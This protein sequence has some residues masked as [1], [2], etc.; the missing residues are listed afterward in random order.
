MTLYI[1]NYNNYYNRIMKRESSIED[2][3]S[4]IIYT[5][6]SSNFNP[7]D[8]I[9]TTHVFGSNAHMYDGSGDYVLV[10][11]EY[12]QIVSRWFI[13]E[14][15]RSRQ[16]QWILDLKRDL[17]ADY[18]D[19]IIE[20]P[21]FIEKGNLLLDDPLIFNS[22]NMTVNQIK[23]EETL[24]KDET[25][26]PW[27]VGYYAKNT[28]LSG[29]VPINISDDIPHIDLDGSISQWE[30][31]P[32][33][34][35]NQAQQNFKGP[36]QTANYK[37]IITV[38]GIPSTPRLYSV[39]AFN[40]STSLVGGS[41][42]LDQIGFGQP[43]T[44]T[45]AEAFVSYG[46]NN[47]NFN[48]YTLNQLQNKFDKILSYDGKIIK[49]TTIGKYYNC[50]ITTYNT[51]TTTNISSG[52]L[53]NKLGEILSPL[54]TNYTPTTNSYT[55][56][57][58]QTEVS[59]QLE[60]LE[61]LE[62]Q[63]SITSAKLITENSPYDIFAI[64]Y[65]KITVKNTGGN[66]LVETNA[67][68][69]LTA[70][71]AIQVNTGVDIIYDIQLL[72]YCPVQELITNTGEITVTNQLQYSLIKKKDSDI[73]VGI[74]FNVSKDNFSFNI[75]NKTV[76]QG[77]SSI[78]RKINNECDKWRLASPNYSNY[79]DFSAEMNN[80][81]EFF[82]VD[83][84]YK[85]YIPYI[86]I[87]PNF[88][89]LYGSDFNDPRGLV[90]GGDFSL[91]QVNDRWQQYQINNK[92]YQNIFDRQI[93]N[94][95]F[96]NTIGLTSDI[97]SAVT[98][99]AQGAVSGGFMGN[100]MPKLG[101][102]PGAAIGAA[103]SALGGAADVVLNS[104]L[105]KEALDYTKD[106]FGFQ[107]G[108]IQALPDTISKISAFNNNNKVF[109]VLEYYT[110]KDREKLA[111]VNKVAWNG[112]TIGVIGNIKDYI[113]NTWEYNYNDDNNFVQTIKSQNYI[114]GKIIRLDTIDEDFHIVN[115]I[116]LELDKGVYIK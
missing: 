92:N 58:T 40:G 100:L 49:D 26:C 106:M 15:V 32:Y 21:C 76:E 43:T 88:D 67:Q 17:F 25:N 12:N 96:K 9:D 107:L 16:G 4:Y 74:I 23:T 10:V 115:S 83:C 14:A 13:I 79:F 54:V 34:N 62:Q 31:Y 111:F 27:L 72:P 80:G 105:R 75:T 8:G 84:N 109:P 69:G 37:F 2:Y 68:Y 77:Q 44:S 51:T 59:I 81:V 18:W 19:Q 93:Q 1:L 48:D 57:T 63:Y 33:C 50:I 55:I 78:E 36:A 94:M 103:A 3:Q 20:S 102:G 5:L 66:V 65:G 35:L 73:A 114:K 99:T 39:N 82:N 52:S 53:F 97:I 24:L 41:S 108:N 91:T 28:D 98:G 45:I 64:P 90:L 86:H 113:N 61:E 110:C 71:A 30:F 87:N 42:S 56:T 46:L 89:G 47:L 116:A 7:T 22:E 70:A 38:P 101:V 29:T 60:E 85:P 95:E 104:A 11:N 112:M 6:E